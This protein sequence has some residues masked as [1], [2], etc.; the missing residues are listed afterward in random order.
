MFFLH[1]LNIQKKPARG[2]LFFYFQK[3]LD[4]DIKIL[5]CP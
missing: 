1:N 4:S 3:Y 5:S 2:K